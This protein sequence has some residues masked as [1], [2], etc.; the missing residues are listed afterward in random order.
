M[1]WEEGCGLS[2][3]C[4]PADPKSS[5]LGRG[6]GT[7][8]DLR[9]CPACS[10]AQGCPVSP[11]P[12][13]EPVTSGC[14]WQSGL[15]V[16]GFHRGGRPPPH[17][18]PQLSPALGCEVPLSRTRLLGASLAGPGGG[19][20]G[21][22]V[23]PPVGFRSSWGLGGAGETIPASLVFL[24]PDAERSGA[25]SGQ[26]PTETVHGTLPSHLRVGP[27]GPPDSAQGTVWLQMRG[28]ESA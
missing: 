11:L 18:H 24:L 14:Q 25:G 1:P 4:L 10:A 16:A 3:R 23:P 7:A 20:Q 12:H 9:P 2:L 17:Q 22:S 6:S 21:G 8:C 13:L 5:G 27:A 28:Q 15:A 26:G 19:G